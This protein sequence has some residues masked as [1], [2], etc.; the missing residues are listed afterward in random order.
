M[1]EQA[2]SDLRA[3]EASAVR[4]HETRAADAA[5]IY[6]DG[7]N[8]LLRGLDPLSGYDIGEAPEQRVMVA[9]FIKSLNSMRCFYELAVRGYFVQALNLMRTPVEDWMAYWFLRNFPER[10]NEFTDSGR[11]P[12]KFNAALQAVE[13]AQYR[14]H[15]TA[16]G[17]QAKLT[18]DKRVRKWMK[19]LHQY[20]HLS[21]DGVREVM[22]FDEKFT[23]YRI[24]PAEDEGRFRACI[25]EALQVLGAQLEALDNFRRLTGEQPLEQFAEYVDRVQAWQK[26][27]PAV[28]HELER[29]R[30]SGDLDAK[31]L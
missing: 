19:N 22:T 6:L 31:S 25:A 27:Q 7:F 10:H 12:P 3:D 5:A 2:E 11:D 15:I 24:G 28:V 20:S 18:P 9:L 26:S 30:G 16:R 21:R 1:A 13:T 23:Y 29:S 8:I 17:P 4:F 14:K